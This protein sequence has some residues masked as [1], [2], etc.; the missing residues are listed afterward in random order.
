[1]VNMHQTTHEVYTFDDTDEGY[2]ASTFDDTDEG[3]YEETDEDT[4]GDE[5]E[6]A[7]D[8]NCPWPGFVNSHNEQNP[9]LLR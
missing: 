2:F 9:F 4:C 7:Y 3:T 5:D 8:R 1:M 6:K